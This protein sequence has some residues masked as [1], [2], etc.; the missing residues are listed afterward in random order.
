MNQAELVVKLIKE[1]LHLRAE[2]SRRNRAGMADCKERDQWD[3]RALV[4]DE[5][6]DFLGGGR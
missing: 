3:A 6:N 2:L 5:L 4:L 1:V